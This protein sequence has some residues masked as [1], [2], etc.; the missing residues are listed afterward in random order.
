[1]F[2]HLTHDPVTPADEMHTQLY[3]IAAYFGWR[4]VAACTLTHHTR[5]HDGPLKQAAMPFKWWYETRG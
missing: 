4:K 5:T 2:S 1:M 3:N